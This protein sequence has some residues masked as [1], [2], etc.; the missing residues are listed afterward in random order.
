MNEKEM[1]IGEL[2]LLF[3]NEKKSKTLCKIRKDFYRAAAICIQKLR[4]R[5]QR[6]LALAP[7][8]KA[9]EMAR[10]EL[11][12]A[13]KDLE[14]IVHSRARK[15][16]K[17]SLQEYFEPSAEFE[18]ALTPE[19]KKFLEGIKAVITQFVTNT[20]LWDK[21]IQQEQIQKSTEKVEREDRKSLPKPE[22]REE[23]SQN[24]QLIV[25]TT[26]GSIAL[27]EQNIFYRKGDIAALGE[28]VAK[29][30]IKE[31]KAQAIYPM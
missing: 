29:I 23:V 8:S 11:E 25:F 4:E 10:R 24:L 26:E 22:P 16:L 9:A 28:R 7:D 2:A 5:Y 20:W 13:K 1:G 31:K 15:I 30:L 27:P 12:R 17:N 6:E 19:E 18:S 3:E 21:S 14:E